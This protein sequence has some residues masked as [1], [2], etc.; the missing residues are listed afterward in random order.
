MVHHRTLHED[1]LRQSVEMASNPNTPAAQS[2]PPQEKFRP[3]IISRNRRRE[4]SPT[5]FAEFNPR[6][7]TH[8][9]GTLD[10]TS[11]KAWKDGVA[12]VRDRM[13][14]FN[15]G[16]RR[17]HRARL[18]A[19]P[20]DHNAGMQIYYKSVGLDEFLEFLDS[21][22]KKQQ[23][24]LNEFNASRAAPGTSEERGL[25]RTLSP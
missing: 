13:D 3:T 12:F 2:F 24:R 7:P 1:N 19:T 21:D 15:R 11:I 23:K 16:L 6:L 18:A 14:S 10:E 22:L 4:R 25:S 20:E 5:A 9:D 17:E 8:R